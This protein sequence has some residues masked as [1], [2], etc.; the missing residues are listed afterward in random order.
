MLALSGRERRS[1]LCFAPAADAGFPPLS[2]A[3]AALL[4]CHEVHDDTGSGRHRRADWLGAAA[5]HGGET[6]ARRLSQPL[7]QAPP[8]LNRCRL[9]LSCQ[10][11]WSLTS[12]RVFAFA[13]AGS[14]SVPSLALLPPAPPPVPDKGPQRGARSPQDF[15][16]TPDLVRVRACY[17]PQLGILLSR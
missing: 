6:G 10:V 17:S 11:Y 9:C 12:E 16:L 3:R 1:R 13:R 8:W 15:K 4:T 5:G 14:D 7:Y 2:L